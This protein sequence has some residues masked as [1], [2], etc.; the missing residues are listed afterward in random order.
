M[1]LSCPC[2][3]E[4]QGGQLRAG[5]EGATHPQPGPRW[6]QG[7]PLVC[8]QLF[9][10]TGHLGPRG[11]RPEPRPGRERR[12]LKPRRVKYHAARLSY[13]CGKRIRLITCRKRSGNPFTRL[14]TREING[15]LPS[16]ARGS[17]S[18]QLVWRCRCRP[19]L[20]GPWAR[21]GCGSATPRNGPEAV[22]RGNRPT[23]NER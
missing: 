1:G 23:S 21:G 14:H 22:G 3:P 4:R 7:C 18:P 20:V 15:T 12:P 17:Q 6:A 19:W 16:A 10:V 2:A 8:M 5:A 9:E 11:R 13:R